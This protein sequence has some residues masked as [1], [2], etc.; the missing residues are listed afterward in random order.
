MNCDNKANVASWIVLQ[1]WRCWQ[2]CICWVSNKN[3]KMEGIS[4]YN[5][6]EFHFKIFR[7]YDPM[8]STVDQNKSKWSR[9]QRSFG[10]ER[11]AVGSTT[12]VNSSLEYCWPTQWHVILFCDLSNS[13][14]SRRMNVENPWFLPLPW[15]LNGKDV[16]LSIV[17][18]SHSDKLSVV[19]CETAAGDAC[20]NDKSNDK[21]ILQ[22]LH[23]TT[24]A[25]PMLW[26]DFEWRYGVFWWLIFQMFEFSS[27]FNIQCP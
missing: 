8:H 9:K 13:R 16:E 5:S 25:M 15:R 17:T 4:P 3:T 2:H 24:N 20:E 10:T 22:T 12:K 1:Y 6:A 7:F 18:P 11:L 14:V 27:I 19:L 26:I 23:H 21:D